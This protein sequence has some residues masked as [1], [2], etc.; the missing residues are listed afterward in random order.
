MVGELEK[1][2]EE[3]VKTKLPA[4]NGREIKA[5]VIFL[6]ELELATKLAD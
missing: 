3:K 1:L 5:N 2:L 6:S 4:D